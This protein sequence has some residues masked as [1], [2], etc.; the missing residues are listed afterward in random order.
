MK[1]TAADIQHSDAV[2]VPELCGGDQ[3]VITARVEQCFI[4]NCAGRHDTHHLALYRPLAGGRVANLFADGD[5]N[6]LFHQPRQIT[7]N[8]MVGYTGHRDRFACGFAPCGEGHIQ[9]TGGFARI[10]KEQLV[11]I[12][13]AV[14]HHLIRVI[15]LN[16]KVLLHH[17]GMGVGSLCW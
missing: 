6:T 15:S 13:H 8:R 10:V 3:Q 14:E 4:A 9:Q 11:E 17:G 12:A 1:A 16:A 7:L 2:T 5:G